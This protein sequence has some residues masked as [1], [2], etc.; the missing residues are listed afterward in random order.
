M[1]ARQPTRPGI[2]PRLVCKADAAAY[3]GVCPAVFDRVCPVPSVSLEEGRRLARWD[4]TKLDEWIDGLTP[5][6][7]DSPPKFDWLRALDAGQGNDRKG[8]QVARN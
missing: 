4:L 7:G 6:R 1:K 3:C 5:D 2:Q 8:D